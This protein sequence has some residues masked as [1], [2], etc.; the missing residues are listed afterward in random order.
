MRELIVAVSLIFTM[1]NLGS[2]FVKVYIKKVVMFEG[3]AVYCKCDFN[4]VF[5]VLIVDIRSRDISQALTSL[6]TSLGKSSVIVGICF[7]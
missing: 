2:I 6:G 5:A 1:V 3:A 4:T 7:S